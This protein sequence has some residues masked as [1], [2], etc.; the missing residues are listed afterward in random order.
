MNDEIECQ[1]LVLYMIRS[2]ARCSES[3]RALLTKKTV[4]LPLQSL[5]H[6]SS[7]RLPCLATSP[8]N[9]VEISLH[10]YFLLPR[11]HIHIAP[12]THALKPQV[13]LNRIPRNA[14]DT[15]YSSDYTAYAGDEWWN[16]SKAESLE[17]IQ[18]FVEE[19]HTLAR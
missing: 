5:C 14:N 19:G 7:N 4:I 15:R 8:R 11:N 17:G 12:Y 13:Q 10:A 18:K 16:T 1:H 6:T 2:F 9:R 3:Q